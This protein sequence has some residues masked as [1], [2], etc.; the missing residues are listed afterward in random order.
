[1]TSDRM[2]RILPFLLPALFLGT[3]WPFI[4]IG[5]DISPVFDL[6]AL[7]SGVAETEGLVSASVES[8]WRS[9]GGG[10]PNGP[11]EACAPLYRTDFSYSA[12]GVP[13]SRSISAVDTAPVGAS[14][15]VQYPLA[16]PSFGQVKGFEYS[17][18][19]RQLRLPQYLALV[20]ILVPLTIW[21]FIFCARALLRRRD[22]VLPPLVDPENPGKRRSLN[23][24]LEMD[25]RRFEKYQIGEDFVETRDRQVRGANMIL[26]V[27][28]L[29][30]FGL[31]G[32]LF[33]VLWNR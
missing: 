5:G 15:T 4:T 23:A 17:I 13:Y 7:V 33:Y 11:P 21:Y 18:S 30:I 3:L 19:G 31:L 16:C 28:S 14:I 1:M 2:N 22:A 25:R 6:C 24:P 8:R 26:G 29:L 9:C 27:L 12:D 20:C 32:V 10:R